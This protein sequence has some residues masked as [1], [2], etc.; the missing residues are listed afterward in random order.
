MT[1]TAV[2]VRHLRDWMAEEIPFLADQ[3]PWERANLIAS[4]IPEI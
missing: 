4:G 1:I 2:T 3:R